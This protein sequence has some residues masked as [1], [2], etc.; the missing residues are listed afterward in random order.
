MG[1]W[2][3]VVIAIDGRDSLPWQTVTWQTVTRQTVC[4]GRQLW[5]AAVVSQVGKFTPNVNSVEG[6]DMRCPR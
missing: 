6:I 5:L 4:R 2:P 3:W 1:S